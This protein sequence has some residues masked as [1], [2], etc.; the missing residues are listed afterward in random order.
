[1]LERTGIVIMVRRCVSYPIMASAI[2]ISA[3]AAVL[4]AHA[5]A[6]TLACEV[7]QFDRAGAELAPDKFTVTYPG[8]ETGELVL[9]GG[10]WG[11]RVALQ[12]TRETRE[13]AVGIRASGPANLTMPDLASVSDC[14]EAAVKANAEA[15]ADGEFN[16]F[17]AMGCRGG[18]KRT[19]QPIAT[20]VRIEIAF[21]D[22]ELL[23]YFSEIWP[24][25][26]SGR[27][28]QLMTIPSFPM[29]KC[30]IVP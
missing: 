8:T 19:A 30:A 18:A 25:D 26:A 11:D 4:P 28:K 23:S 21:V 12:G 1:M 10:S 17:L 13:N 16:D 3:L 9:S 2:A 7:A 20:T 15:T 24:T 14:Y 22:G 6:V 27:D 5:A 29:P